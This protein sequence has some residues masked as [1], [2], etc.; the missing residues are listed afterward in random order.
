MKELK[1][2]RGRQARLL[3]FPCNCTMKELKR[4]LKDAIN[5]LRKN[6]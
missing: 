6:L 4:E 3:Q 5:E 1:L 2:E